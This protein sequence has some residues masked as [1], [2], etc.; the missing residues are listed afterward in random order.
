VTLRGTAGADRLIGT[1]GPDTLLGLGGNDYLEAR[2]GNDS[3][4]AGTGSDTV[5]T[6][7]GADRIQVA[8]DGSADRVDCGPG[9]DTLTA[10]LP[11]KT[12]A[13]CELVSRQLSRDPFHGLGAQDG[14]E[15]EPDSA[16][17]GSVVVAAFQ[18][19]RFVDGG[20]LAIGFST[21]KNAGRTW[22]SGLLP[23]LSRAA[24]P[25]GA[26]ELVADPSVAYD[27]AHRTW[28]I[29]SLAALPN[30]DAVQ[31][32]R[33]RDGLRWQAPVTAV[34]SDGVDK[35][36]IAC[37]NWAGSPFRGRCYLTYLDDE[38]GGIVM[39]TTRDGGR[40][41]SQRV[42]VAVGANVNGAQ[43]LIRP[44]G[45]VVVAFTVIAPG[46]EL[47]RQEIAIAKSAD[48]GASFGPAQRVAF[49]GG[50][51]FWILGIRAPQFVSGDV[52]AGGIVYLAW[53]GC[54]DP[55]YCSST[56][57]V[58][59]RSADA[60]NWS[61]PEQLP[62]V[63]GGASVSSFLPGLAVEPG[64]KGKRAQV[65]IAYYAMSCNG[66]TPCTLDVFLIRSP[67]GGATWNVPERLN[68]ESMR[69]FW[70]ADTNVGRML[71]DYISTSFAGRRPV[72]VFALAAAP[73]KGRFSEA[74]F[75]TRM[76]G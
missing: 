66:I 47:G 36:W 27:A 48:G 11:D 13:N 2:R 71:G 19:G 16:S 7:P 64:T 40:T 72:P 38:A 44:N 8:F 51:S 41:W 12:A 69:L 60:V 32:S 37:D 18:V 17:Y 6:G 54:D 25:A 30:S 33:S 29:A 57:I 61:A 28:L 53:H 49:A 1:A 46:P 10:E 42:P 3:L 67:D 73:G 9:R 15:V 5:F 76:P 23:S 75:A 43:P 74:I 68:P 70:L 22:R 58:V 21:S 55:D 4:D 31:I 62:V 14:T 50:E 34:E 56:R 26:A 39:Q 59:S 24:A 45:T 20:A 52:D 35:N 65:A 63:P